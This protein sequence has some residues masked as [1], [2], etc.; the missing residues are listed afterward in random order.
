[1]PSDLIRGWEPVFGKEHAP[2]EV[3]HRFGH[4]TGFGET[5]NSITG[6]VGNVLETIS[7]Q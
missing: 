4:K 3:E 2:S 1:M 7:A 5:V 6:G